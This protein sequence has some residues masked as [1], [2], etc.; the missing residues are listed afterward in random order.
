MYKI[1]VTFSLKTDIF[2]MG[3][4][5]ERQFGVEDQGWVA[6]LTIATLTSNPITI[7]GDR[8]QVRDI[9][10][11]RDLVKAF[12]LFLESNLI[13]EVFNNG[14][15]VE[16]TLSLLE[17]LDLLEKLTGKKS[18]MNHDNWKP[19]DQKVH[20]SDIIKAKNALGW[21]L[22]VDLNEGIGKLVKLVKQNKRIFN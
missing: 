10:Y 18:E 13:Q 7:Y 21:R 22:E 15:S 20:I 4:D 19:S 5:G 14:G 11:V 6:W 9:L 16:N 1:T 8:K 3:I 17:L 12:D 2:R